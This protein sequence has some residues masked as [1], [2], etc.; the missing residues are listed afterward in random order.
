MQGSFKLQNSPSAC[1][2]VAATEGFVGLA[3]G[4][5]AALSADPN[6]FFQKLWLYPASGVVAGVLSANA[7]N[8]RVGKSGTGT[9]TVTKL[10]RKGAEITV[11]AAG[12]TLRNGQAVLIANAN[13][14]EYNGTFEIYEVTDHDFKYRALTA[15]TADATG[16]ITAVVTPYLPDTLAPTDGPLLIEVPLGQ[17]MWLGLI[18]IKGTA[19]DG[20]FYSYT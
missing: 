18:I 20:I 2:P 7:A 8:L 4:N 10:Y 9:A 5:I 14:S 19:N 3:D 12:H 13:Q 15:P 16:A 17:K 6:Q 1:R 11:A